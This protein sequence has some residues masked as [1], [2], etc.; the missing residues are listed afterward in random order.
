L[1]GAPGKGPNPVR[2]MFIGCFVLKLTWDRQS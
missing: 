2:R 1:N